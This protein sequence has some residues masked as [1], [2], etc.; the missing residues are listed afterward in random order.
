MFSAR[1]GSSCGLPMVIDPG[2][3][4]GAFG[5]V[6]AVMVGERLLSCGRAITFDQAP[7]EP[8]GRA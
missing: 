4:L 2:A 7:R 6:M 8:A 3:V 1:N 5:V